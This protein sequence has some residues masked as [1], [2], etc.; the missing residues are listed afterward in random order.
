[1]IDDAMLDKFMKAYVG[2]MLFAETDDA[3]EPLDEN[4][5]FEDISPEAWS[6]ILEDCYN[7]LKHNYDDVNAYGVRLSGTYFFFT[8][9]GHGDG[10]LSNGQSKLAERLD[11]AAERYG[12]RYGEVMPLVNSNE[13]IYI[14]AV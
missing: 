5:G 10:F 13:Q 8:R 2:A 3:L 6:L 14:V 4:Y 1:M 7:F 11:E 12:E 9:N